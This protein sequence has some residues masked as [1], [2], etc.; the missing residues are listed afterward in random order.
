MRIGTIVGGERMWTWATAVLGVFL[1]GQGGVLVS[2]SLPKKPEGPQ[3]G[4]VLPDTRV[5]ASDGHLTSLRKELSS[6]SGCTVLVVVSPQCSFC[7]QMR[8][9]WPPVFR[10]WSDSVGGAVRAIW[11]SNFDSSSLASFYQGYDLR[12]TTKLRMTVMSD[13]LMH[14]LGI[15][16]TP[17]TYL[18]D[19]Q[20]LLRFGTLDLS[21]PPVDSAKRF[22]TGART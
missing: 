18:L 11:L 17:T 6:G 22:C 14:R 8:I 16:A 19:R 2:R 21:L 3:V 20:G 1:L 13:S 12:E 10:A 15:Y 9:W 7:Q 5:V 4:S